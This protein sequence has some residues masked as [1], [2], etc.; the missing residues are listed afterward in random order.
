[1]SKTLTLVGKTRSFFRMDTLPVFYFLTEEM[2]TTSCLGVIGRLF[3]HNCPFSALI[4]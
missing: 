1:M 2:L 3:G 4:K